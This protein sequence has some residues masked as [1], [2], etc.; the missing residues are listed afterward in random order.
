LRITKVPA[1]RTV[2]AGAHVRYRIRVQALG[3]VA[4]VGVRVCDQL[5][6]YQAISA[7][8]GAKLSHGQPCWSIPVLDPGR[9]RVFTIELIA[10]NVP[11]RLS[12]HDTAT[13]SAHNA[14]TVKTRAAIRIAP[15]PTTTPS[16]VTG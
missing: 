13:A 3:S 7:A 16:P 1:P 2:T 15:R 14:P 4:A 8:P 5:G 9:P 11:S 6:P 10:L 12:A